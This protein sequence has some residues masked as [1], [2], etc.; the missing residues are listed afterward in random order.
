[1]INFKSLLVGILT[2]NL[3]WI[4]WRWNSSYKI[5]VTKW[6]ILF[7]EMWFSL[8]FAPFFAFAAF[9]TASTTFFKALAKLVSAFF[10]NFSADFSSFTI[11]F[12]ASLNFA[13]AKSWTNLTAKWVT[14]LTTLC[15]K[16]SYLVCSFTN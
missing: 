1:M 10:S 14:L 13:A 7:S 3:E 9:L 16:V 11:Y 15:S 12:S 4:L 2:C 8:F 6:I 5:L